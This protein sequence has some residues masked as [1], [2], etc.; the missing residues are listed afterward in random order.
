MGKM[1][2]ILLGIA[3]AGLLIGTAFSAGLLNVENIVAFYI[4]L[5][6]GA[7]FFG[8]FLIF[9]MLEKESA[10]F[11]QDHQAALTAKRLTACQ[12]SKTQ[13]TCC[14]E[15]REHKSTLASAAAK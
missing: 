6:L 13:E 5:P 11:D 12:T 1:T 9:L 15:K 4:V 2:K 3:L 10:L 7:V 14:C 8:L